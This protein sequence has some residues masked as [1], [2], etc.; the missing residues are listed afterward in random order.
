MCVCVG[1][2]GTSCLVHLFY[3]PFLPDRSKTKKNYPNNMVIMITGSFRSRSCF[4][5]IIIIQPINPLK[6]CDT[7]G[8]SNAK[9]LSLSSNSDLFAYR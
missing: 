8:L 4:R 1:S 9:R 5:K 3:S 2:T 6:M 7:D